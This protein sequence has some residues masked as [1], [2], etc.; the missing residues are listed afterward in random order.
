M[1]SSTSVAILASVLIDVMYVNMC[2]IS[3]LL[4]LRDG[5]VLMLIPQWWKSL[6]STSRMSPVSVTLQNT[7]FSDSS[8]HFDTVMT[9][10][11]KR[12]M[13][14]WM[15]EVPAIKQIFVTVRN[16]W[17]L[18][19]DFCLNHGGQLDVLMWTMLYMLILINMMVRVLFNSVSD[20]PGVLLL[21][22]SFF[23]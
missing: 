12:L 14:F 3:L 16:A 13:C 17:T 21:F 20:L 1:I 4:Y 22:F 7:D 23:S 2:N 6:C 9:V 10:N 11:F 15:S 5:V 8:S 19:C 18:V